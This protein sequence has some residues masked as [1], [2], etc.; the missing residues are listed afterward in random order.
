MIT[1]AIKDKL[2]K[3]VSK[4]HYKEAEYFI[5]KLKTQVVKDD[6]SVYF[7]EDVL[8]E[9][10]R[11]YD[12]MVEV[13]LN[14]DEENDEFLIEFNCGSNYLELVFSTDGFTYNFTSDSDKNINSGIIKDDVHGEILEKAKY[15]KEIIDKLA[16]I[17]NVIDQEGLI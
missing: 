3:V 16:L 10:D 12:E 8:D 5:K 11:D 14:L 2:L 4:T 7:N 9:D 17:V 15:N 13:F 6:K 1:Q